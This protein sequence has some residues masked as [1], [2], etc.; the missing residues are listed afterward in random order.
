MPTALISRATRTPTADL[1][2]GCGQP[3]SRTR[4]HAVG[5]SGSAKVSGTACKSKS[6]ARSP[7]EERKQVDSKPALSQARQ[8]LSREAPVVTAPFPGSALVPAA[9]SHLHPLRL[10]RVDFHHVAGRY[11]GP[12]NSDDHEQGSGHGLG[13][14]A[15]R[16]N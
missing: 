10:R 3:S 13:H 12:G 11:L 4:F 14:P 1:R 2:P 8:A 7:L 9:Q 6:S 5:S 16:G 15:T